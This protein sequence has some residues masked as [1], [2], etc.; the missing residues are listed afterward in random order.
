MVLGSAAIVLFLAFAF[1]GTRSLWDPDEGRYTNVA[2]NM[3]ESGDWVH[4]VRNE[5]IGHWTKPPLTYWIIAT[6]VQAFGYNTW[7]ARL[8]YGLSYLF[9][10][11][12]VWRIARRVVPGGELRAALTY[13]TM[14]LPFCASQI[15][16]TD[17][18]LA[19]ELSLAMMAWI[20]SRFVAPNYAARWV[21][22]MWLGLALGFL[23]KGPPALLPIL[24]IALSEW[25]LPKRD[26]TSVYHWSGVALFLI[27]ALPWYVVV[28][29]N[30]DG[31]L[32]YFFGNELV[33][34]VA[35]DNH[36]RHGEWYAWLEIY[37]PTLLIG[38]LPWTVLLLRW[39]TS[40]KFSL[41]IWRDPELRQTD[42]AGLMLFLWIFLPLL[43][44]CL[45]R[46][47]LPLYLLPLFT[48]LALV[49]ARQWQADGRTF[50]RLRWLAVW[51]V[52]LVAFRVATAYW[53]T[54]KNAGDWADA[55]RERA[56][57]A[58][59]EVVF[60]E[61]M[62]RYGVHLHLGA[63][64]DK[65]AMSPEAIDAF[66]SDYDASIDSELAERDSSIIY[67]CK[68][69]NWQELKSLLESRGFTAQELGDTFHGRV[70]A[71]VLPP[72]EPGSVAE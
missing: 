59:R 29:G 44:F 46:S 37:A 10:I 71:S 9:C 57:T 62:A 4:P 54:Q 40:L 18:L 28:A 39:I 33:D 20:E 8:P 11:W 32:G 63:H 26:R 31:L 41:R 12:M 58:V 48:P 42:P 22:I 19:A 52:V 60:V 3:L 6:S 36:G 23:T 17:F 67:I 69:K 49:I 65:L 24:A 27:V 25:L 34:R 50:P 47:R 51:A 53:P 5:H 13:A 30:V 72:G 64:V 56:G 45:A 15:V 35:S 2:L 14:F 55:I 7:A 43:V 1:L 66:S 70:I 61:D 21:R 38:S 16:T 68:Q